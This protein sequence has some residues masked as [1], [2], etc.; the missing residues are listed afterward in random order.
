MTSCTPD[1]SVFFATQAGLLAEAIF[2]STKATT[3]VVGRSAAAAGAAM[4]S[5]TGQVIFFAAGNL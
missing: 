1:A 4:G 3:G 2:P 5:R